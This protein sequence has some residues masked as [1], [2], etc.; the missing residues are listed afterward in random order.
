MTLQERLEDA[1]NAYHDLVTGKAVVEVVD[2]NGERVRYS[3][4]NRSALLSYI[5]E[6]KWQI[7][8]TSVA[9]MQFWGRS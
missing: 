9:P 6:L 1:E 2:Q 7:N 5:G 8:N 3:A 4:A